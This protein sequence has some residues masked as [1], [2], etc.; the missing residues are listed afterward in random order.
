[1]NDTNIG[2]GGSLNKITFPDASQFVPVAPGFQPNYS[3]SITQ[4]DFILPLIPLTAGNPQLAPP[5]V[6]PGV[7]LM[8]VENRMAQ[9]SIESLEAWGE[10]IAEIAARIKEEIN[11]PDYLAKEEENKKIAKGTSETQISIVAPSN[12]L[13]V[14]SS[15]TD[16][17]ERYAR[18]GALE[19]AIMGAFALQNAS[20]V[21]ADQNAQNAR[22]DVSKGG[23]S[24]VSGVSGLS[25]TSAIGAVDAALK[26]DASNQAVSSNAATSGISGKAALEAQR[27]TENA[28][29]IPS[30]SPSFGVQ[31]LVALASEVVL[32]QNTSLI[33]NA[34]ATNGMHPETKVVQDAWSAISA[35]A[36]DPATLVAGWVSAMWGIG[37][38]YQMSADKVATQTADKPKDKVQDMNFAKT[39]AAKV[40]AMVDNPKFAST[41]Q[42]MMMTTVER[43]PE[44]DASNPN[45]N[46]LLTK[47]KLTLLSLAL[48][49]MG[50]LEVGSHADKGWINEMEFD[51]LLDGKTDLT[52]NDLFETAGLKRALIDKINVLLA[53]LDPSE[54]ADVRASLRAYMSNNP[55]VESLLDQ[56][57]AIALATNP[58]T[59]D[60]GLI[61]KVC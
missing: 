61:E 17:A 27:G 7:I 51:G 13:V 28:G 4:S 20:G 14:Q 18:L 2:N 5:V 50:K 43:T 12:D 23:M 31:S 30:G 22:I 9:I 60:D 38:I 34:A 37:L 25:S 26:A 40:L 57:T 24:G 19:A 56:Q 58:P 41:M 32:F 46:T 6:D 8:A 10:S 44:M 16:L 1:M 35:Q 53:S 36:S 3:D 29:I 39:Y 49:L 45:F 42:A 54:R 59:L 48:A 55:S 33:A 21:S 52:K 15:T 11:S 47:A